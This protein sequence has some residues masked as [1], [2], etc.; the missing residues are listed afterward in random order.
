MGLLFA[1]LIFVGIFAIYDAIRRVN[2]NIL[3]Q[4]SEIKKLRED[5]EQIK[6]NSISS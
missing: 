5:I 3:E 6:K 2:N 1:I 4:T